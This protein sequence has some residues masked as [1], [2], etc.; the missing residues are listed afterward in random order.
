NPDRYTDTKNIMRLNGPHQEYLGITFAENQR[1][2]TKISDKNAPLRLMFYHRNPLLEVRSS[3]Q[4]I[5]GH[6]YYQKTKESIAYIDMPLQ[7]GH[8]WVEKSTRFTKYER[9]DD[10]MS[11]RINDVGKLTFDDMKDGK[12]KIVL[13][14]TELAQEDTTHYKRPEGAA[15]VE[16]D[17]EW[18][19]GRFVL[20]KYMDD[21]KTDSTTMVEGLGNTLWLEPKNGPNPWLFDSNGK[22][23][24]ATGR[25]S[26]WIDPKSREDDPWPL[27]YRKEYDEDYLRI[28]AILDRVS[29]GEISF[30]ETGLREPTEADEKAGHLYYRAVRSAK[31][32]Y[33]RNKE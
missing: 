3:E 9:D 29:A 24:K 30:E 33:E 18:K 20:P 15:K 32:A 27:R 1:V 31:V 25:N 11:N 4:R 14:S 8:A 13:F 16:Y 5:F 7:A 28:S 6:L 26:S 19:N 21:Q 22:Q 2:P 10:P 12:Y 17:F 23:P